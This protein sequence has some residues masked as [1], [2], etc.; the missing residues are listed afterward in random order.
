[1]VVSLVL[2]MRSY[3]A[4]YEHSEKE[5]RRLQALVQEKVGLAR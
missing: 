5:A 4:K 2:Q 1:M 3:K